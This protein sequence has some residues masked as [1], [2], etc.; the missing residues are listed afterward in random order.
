MCI[1]RC[2]NGKPTHKQNSTRDPG[3]NITQTTDDRTH[4][5]THSQNANRRGADTSALEIAITLLT[6]FPLNVHHLLLSA[7]QS[8]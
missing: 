3:L 4:M 8:A 6:F 2:T 1:L 5:D 7:A